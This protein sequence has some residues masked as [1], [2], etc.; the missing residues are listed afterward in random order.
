MG[1][2]LMMLCRRL[3][4]CL[5]NCLMPSAQDM[6]ERVQVRNSV[7]QVFNKEPEF[8]VI[9][10]SNESWVLSKSVKAN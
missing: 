10:V 9:L 7:V 6:W 1:T 4:S 5:C 8:L 2:S 3:I